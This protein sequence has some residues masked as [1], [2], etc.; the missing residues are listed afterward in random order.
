MRGRGLTLLLAIVIGLTIWLLSKGILYLYWRWRY[1]SQRDIGI[2]RAPLLYYSYRLVTAIFIIFSILMVFYVRG[3]VLFLTLSIIVLVAAAL[4]MRQTL[5]RYAAEIRLLL[6]VGPVRESERL[7]L[8]GIPF[9]VD[10][11]SVYTVLRNPVLVG[12]VRLPLHTMNTFASRPAGKE[13]CFPC[14]PED[15]VILANGSLAQ[16]LRQTIELVEVAVMDSKIQIRTSDFIEQNT[17]NLSRAGF[18]ISCTFGIDYQHQAICLTTVPDL[19]RE[20]IIAR[21]DEAK[22]KDDIVDV[23][24][25]FSSAG[26]SSLDYRI[27][28]VL[29]GSAANAFYKAQRMIQQACVATCNRENWVIP[30]T[31]ITVHSTPTDEAITLQKAITTGNMT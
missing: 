18:G 26:S 15:Y 4:T 24:V 31:Q 9:I 23:L 1:H 2:T 25:E 20:A 12:I 10:T 29:K 28:L 17:R 30:F 5:P 11:L 6:G 19:F 21:F 7:V 8:D 27:Y 13:P 22:M 14:Q 16:V 3:D